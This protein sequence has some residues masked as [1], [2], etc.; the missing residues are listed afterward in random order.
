MNIRKSDRIAGLQVIVPDVFHDFRGEFACTFNTT[1]YR[2]AD[3]LGAEI[4]FVEDDISVSRRHVLRGLHGDTVTWKLVQCLYG[5]TYYVVA[6][7]R[8]DSN[9]YLKWESFALNERT[10]MQVLVPSGCVNGYL[11]LSDSCV[12]SYKQSQRY[13]GG[14]QQ[15][16]VLWNDTKLG[17]FWPI[18]S[19]IL[20]ER[21]ASARP[22]DN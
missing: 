16:T 11:T 3:M 15:L 17:I 19:P 18:Q 12:F 1:D 4:G 9:T 13:S 6:D 22:L 10:R 7:M 14:A 5:E 21:D 8:P 20:S 2:F